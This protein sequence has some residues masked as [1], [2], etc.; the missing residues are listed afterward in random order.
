MVSIED[1]MAKI[2]AGFDEA[3]EYARGNK[4]EVPAGG[5]DMPPK[6]DMYDFT[7]P[8]G[9]MPLV[10]PP[11]QFRRFEAEGVD[12]RWFACPKRIPSAAGQ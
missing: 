3:D 6:T 2:K 8:S 4:T 12:M 5:Y 7:T 1:V 10:M 9:R 11:S